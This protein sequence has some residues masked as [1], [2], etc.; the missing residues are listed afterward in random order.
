MIRKLCFPTQL[1]KAHRMKVICAEHDISISQFFQVLL[2]R[3][4]E[5]YENNHETISIHDIFQEAKK[6]KEKR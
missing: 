4:L 6:R 2:D 1:E 5:A 3:F